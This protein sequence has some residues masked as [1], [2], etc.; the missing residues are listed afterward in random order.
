MPWMGVGVYVARAARSSVRTGFDAVD[1]FVAFVVFFGALLRAAGFLAAG[2][3]FMPRTLQ[4]AR[5]S[6]NARD[7][8]AGRL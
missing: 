4:P 3:F 7:G 5:A 2:R 8:A 1:A 6:V